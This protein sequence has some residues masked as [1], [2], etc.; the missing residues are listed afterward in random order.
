[1]ELSVSK[2]EKVNRDYA[3]YTMCGNPRTEG[4]MSAY[5]SIPG[6]VWEFPTNT[7][8]ITLKKIFDKT[9]SGSEQLKRRQNPYSLNDAEFGTWT[10]DGLNITSGILNLSAP[11]SSVLQ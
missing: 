2:E 5:F 4:I 1:M 8:S 3:S 10:M 11:I 6:I 7:Q 9:I